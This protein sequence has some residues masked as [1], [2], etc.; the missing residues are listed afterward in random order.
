MKK[1]GVITVRMSAKEKHKID[2]ARRRLGLSQSS[3][4]REAVATY[5]E[6]GSKKAARAA[7]RMQSYIG[8]CDSGGL[9]FSEK[10]G[11]RFA[12]ELFKNAKRRSR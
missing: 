9:N 12:D 8:I 10:T 6:R 4:V 2:V 1:D 11:R 7:E 3:F 5:A